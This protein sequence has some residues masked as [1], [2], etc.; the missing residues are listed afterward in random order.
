MFSKLLRRFISALPGKGSKVVLSFQMSPWA[1]HCRVAVELDRSTCCIY[2][3]DKR[4]MTVGLKNRA[5][6]WNS[7]SIGYRSAFLSPGK[8]PLCVF[9]I[10][11]F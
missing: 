6:F 3:S 10:Q 9:A 7:G 11:L 4:E 5:F 8:T 2:H 1:T